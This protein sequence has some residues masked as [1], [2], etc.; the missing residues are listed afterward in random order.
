MLHSFRR[1]DRLG[2]GIGTSRMLN[3]V[4]TR[5]HILVDTGRYAH[6]ATGSREIASSQHKPK[7]S[8][9]PRGVRAPR[10][11]DRSLPSITTVDQT[12]VA[13]ED[14]ISWGGKLYC[15][16]SVKYSDGERERSK[17]GIKYHQAR[18]IGFMRFP[19]HAHGFLYYHPP[20]S[21]VFVPE[22]NE[23]DVGHI[24]F[25]CLADPET[26]FQEGQDLLLP[27]GVPWHMSGLRFVRNVGKP[28]FKLALQAG[29]V[30]QD[31]LA[32]WSP[33]MQP[34]SHRN[35][36][37]HRA[38]HIHSFSQ[39]FALHLNS[40]ENHVRFLG[41][42]PD[43]ED[44]SIKL[45][46]RTGIFGK[47]KPEGLVKPCH[48]NG[49]LVCHLEAHS[50]DEQGELSS[51]ALRV[52]RVIEPAR[53]IPGLPVTI[54]QPKAGEL[55]QWPYAYRAPGAGNR[56]YKLDIRPWELS[57]HHHNTNILTRE[58]LRKLHNVQRAGEEKNG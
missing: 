47:E 17:F 2:R 12:K 58:G 55:L 34:F 13:R 6:S 36:P 44:H 33:L 10:A 8:P 11:T 20:N 40:T 22:F 14:W 49:V 35:N 29:L 1:L 50:F 57:L 18:D 46:I 23:F 4:F 24:R 16:F 9:S 31:D 21:D 45:Y 54:P 26:P 15:R 39:P 51:I 19:A 3:A 27:T 56:V 37:S 38:R 5:R 30:T 28:L 7:R 52:D 53:Q 41:T 48:T 43:G 42:N 32:A 25:R